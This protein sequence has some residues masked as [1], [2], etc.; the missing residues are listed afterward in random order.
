MDKGVLL[1]IIGGLAVFIVLVSFIII[2]NY[3]DF[4]VQLIEQVDD[5]VPANELMLQI[6]KETENLKYKVRKRFESNVLDKKYWGNGN[7]A[8]TNDYQYYS[9]N[10]Q[11]EIKMIN[12][13]DNVRKKFAKKE[14][15]KDEFIY[16]IE[17]F[18]E[19][20]KLYL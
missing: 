4:D 2:S 10:Y 14:I 5:G 18:R 11:N 15:S 3:S 20:F 8:S 6:D 12:E 17:N 16:Q 13:Y 19:Y 7:L 1:G 9:Q